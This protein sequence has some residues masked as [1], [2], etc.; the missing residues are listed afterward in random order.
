MA[1]KGT[2]AG[3]AGIG[4]L[5]VWSGLRGASITGSLRDLIAGK[6]PKSGVNPIVGATQLNMPGATPG[7]GFAGTTSDIAG[8]ALRYRGLVPY[9]WGGASPA[10]WDCSSMV[11]YVLG[12]DLGLA[13][14][15]HANG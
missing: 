9:K 6:Q 10:G 5:L 4:I 3:I 2:A 12:H 14:P 15:G 13:I 11:N 7:A 1:G 8:D